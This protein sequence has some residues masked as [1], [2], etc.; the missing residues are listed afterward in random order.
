MKTLDQI[1]AQLQ[2][3]DPHALSAS[4]VNEFLSHMVEPVQQTEQVGILDALGRVLAQDLI[5]PLSVPPHDNSAMD[6]FAFAGTQLSDSAALELTLVGTAFAGAA[7]R[8]HVGAGECLKVMTGAVLPEGL[9]TVVPQELV[10]VSVR[11]GATWISI[12]AGLL[13]AG[14]NRR[15]VGEDIQQGQAALLNGCLLTPAT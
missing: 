1:A 13:S 15:V 8:G 5:S 12:P 9:D 14:D 2:G 6:G 3:Y 4:A 11:D 10:Q 7:W